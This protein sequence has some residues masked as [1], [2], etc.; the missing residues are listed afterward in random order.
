MTPTKKTTDHF[1]RYLFKKKMEYWVFYQNDK[2]EC[3][4]L[5]D[6][7]YFQ[8]KMNLNMIAI[9]IIN[10]SAQKLCYNSCELQI[11]I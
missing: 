10:K 6:V 11:I 7:N 1:G 5:E 4:K 2:T 8:S 9:K 3:H